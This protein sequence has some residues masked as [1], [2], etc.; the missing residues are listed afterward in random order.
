MNKLPLK[1]SAVAISI[2]LL[3]CIAAITPVIQATN[4]RNETTTPQTMDDQNAILCGYVHDATTGDPLANVDVEENYHIDETHYNWN[5]TTTDENGFYLFHTPAAVYTLY[6]DIQEYFDEHT[7]EQT[8]GENSIIWTNISMIP[9]PPITVMIKGYVT[10]SISQAPLP[11]ASVQ[12]SWHDTNGHYWSN[13]TTTNG[14]GY[15]S[16]G[17]IPGVT[18]VYCSLD[19]YYTF[20][21]PQYNT[22]NGSLLWANISLVPMP[23]ASVYLTGYIADRQTHDP[24]PQASISVTCQ[25]ENGSWYNYTNAN[26][27][28]FYLIGAI[29]SR[30]RIHVYA[31]Q[32]TSYSDYVSLTDNETLWFNITLDYRPTNTSAI[33]GY[34]TDNLTYAAIRGAF[35]RCDWK[36]TLG[37]FYSTYTFTNPQGRYTL[38]VPEG[39]LQLEITAF[40]YG[41]ITLPW[42][43][44]NADTTRWENATLTPEITMKITKPTS[45]VYIN[46]TRVPII[47]WF[48]KAFRPLVIGPLDI[49][50]N[51][52]AS[53]LGCARVE[54]YIDGLHV[55][56]AIE[57]PYLYH[58]AGQGIRIHSIRVIAYDNAG[59]CTIKEFAV[60]KIR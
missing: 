14:T 42:F 51:I 6:F 33:T 45:G 47:S 17:A 44:Q 12:I 39:S 60:R 50:A 25:T 30:V 13:I 28:G 37:H 34:I 15:Y 48:F 41:S 53:S 57:P 35:I 54:F 18:Y 20:Q 16:L 49:T 3:M 10:D 5:S 32:Y 52:T 40:G 11:D 43:D 27:I 58:W 19:E 22:Q 1:Q 7:Q 56:T 29:P 24:I 26:N 21:S 38:P 4:P 31:S 8:I 23:A 2:I 55:G 59:P 36:D 9:V 46:N